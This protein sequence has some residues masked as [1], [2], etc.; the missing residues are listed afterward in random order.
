LAYSLPQRGISIEVYDQF[1]SMLTPWLCDE[2]I[3]EWM[4]LF[5]ES[6]QSTYLYNF[7]G[8]FEN[9]KKTFLKLINA[10]SVYGQ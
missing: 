8:S 2:D 6:D 4:I 9:I 7:N 1:D 5:T 3:A 10:V